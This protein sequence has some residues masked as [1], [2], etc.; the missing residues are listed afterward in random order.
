MAFP[1]P[2][3][4]PTEPLARAD[5]HFWAQFTADKLSRTLFKAL[6]AEDGEA[7]RGAGSPRR[8]G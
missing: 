1:G 2:P 7:R 8:R 6:W 3:L 4:L 5:A